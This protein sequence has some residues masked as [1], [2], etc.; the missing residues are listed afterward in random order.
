[1]KLIP[2]SP[3]W[4]IAEP[5]AAQEAVAAKVA[6]AAGIPILIA[7]DDPVSRTLVVN[8]VEKWGFPSIVTLNGRE[9]IEALR[10]E[11][12]SVIALLDWM[13]PEMDGLEVCRRVRDS[14]KP[15]YII[16]L[17][18][19]GA[20][21]NI[22]E[23]LRAG[24]DDYLVKPYHKEELFARIQVGLRIL[25]LHNSLVQRIAELENATAE[26]ERLKNDLMF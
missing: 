17:T 3:P 5:L 9:A 16:L 7:E 20:K 21:E 2:F 1:M 4:Q 22:V 15:I 10:A 13:M 14:G 8:L 12:G 26:V 6:R 23:G 25:D 24:A 11:Q 18:A 19:R